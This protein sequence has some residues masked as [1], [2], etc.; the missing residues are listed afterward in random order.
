MIKATSK[1]GQV[2]FLGH[3][4]DP[5]L[6]LAQSVSLPVS[7]YL[8]SSVDVLTTGRGQYTCDEYLLLNNVS[9]ILS[10]L[11]LLC[12]PHIFESKD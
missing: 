7:L 5:L 6:F 1:Q 11:L 12:N 3:G 8:V 10:L 9:R 4:L 2:Y